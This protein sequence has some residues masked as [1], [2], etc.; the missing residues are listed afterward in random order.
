M[1]AAKGIN[2]RLSPKVRKWI[3][4]RDK[5]EKKSHKSKIVIGGDYPA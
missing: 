3:K 5:W 1:K 4:D 2:I